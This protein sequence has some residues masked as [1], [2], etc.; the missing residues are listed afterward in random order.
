M[1]FVINSAG[2]CTR[3]FCHIAVLAGVALWLSEAVGFIMD[4]YSR[5]GYCFYAWEDFLDKPPRIS[6]EKSTEDRYGPRGLSL[7]VQEFCMILHESDV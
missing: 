6:H 5:G 1:I 2:E 3:F 4:G 7:T